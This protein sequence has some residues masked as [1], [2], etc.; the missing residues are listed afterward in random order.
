MAGL[1]A[2]N[3]LR[4]YE[5]EVHELQPSLPFNHGALLRFRTDA[6]AKATGQPFTRVRVH[7]AVLWNG[8]LV[9]T[10]TLQMA[11]SYSLK[12]TGRVLPRSILNTDP[13][14]RWIAPP[15]F[16]E[17]MTKGVNIIY[18]SGLDKVGIIDSEIFGPTISTIP[19]PSLMELVEWRDRPIFLYDSIIS[20]ATKIIDP[21]VNVYQ[22]IYA[23]SKEVPWY[24]ASITGDT[25]ILEYMYHDWPDEDYHS[26]SSEEKR[27]QCFAEIMRTLELFGFGGNSFDLEVDIPTVKFQKFG[28]LKPIDDIVRRSFIYGMTQK[29]GIYSLGRFGTWR[30]LLLDDVVNDVNVIDRF[31]QDQTEYTRHLGS[32]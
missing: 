12:V 23:P 22:T 18:G 17:K 16:I 11:N 14:D 26:M 6:V 19:M 7:K 24:R 29:Y 21:M 1:L 4:R 31:L 32:I 27:D 28:K 15:D 9:K 25:L 8:S 13:V 10:P 30:Q 3:M 2:A 20:V 5:P